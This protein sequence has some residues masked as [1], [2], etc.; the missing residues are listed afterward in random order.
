MTVIELSPRVLNSLQQVARQQ[1]AS[2]E[3]IIEELIDRYLREQ[4]HWQLL[5][6]M[7]RFRQQHSQLIPQFRG[8]YI[9]MLNGQVLDSDADGGALHTRLARQYGALPILIVEVTDQPEQE[10]KRLGRHLGYHP[11]EPSLLRVWDNEQ[12]AAYDDWRNLYGIA[13]D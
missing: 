5:Q 8:K 2:V 9:G 10:F 11:L 3:E 1:E 4:R 7:D 6:E 12:D 13:D